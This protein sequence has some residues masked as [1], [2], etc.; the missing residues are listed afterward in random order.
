MGAPSGHVGT[1]KV[2]KLSRWRIAAAAAVLASLLF[3][4]VRLAPYYYRNYRF[5]QYVEEM[6][7]RES[8]LRQSD[9]VLRTLL[10]EKAAALDLPVKANNVLV[11]RSPG[12]LRIDIR[13]VVRVNLPVY[14]VDLHFYPGAGAR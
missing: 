13:Y 12:G 8:S 14:T 9:D 5:Q 6:T 11:K 10:T 1:A 2:L 7:Q 4:A 3:F